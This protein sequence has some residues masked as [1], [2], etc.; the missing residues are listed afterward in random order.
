LI[1]GAPSGEPAEL[2]WIEDTAWLK[3]MGQWN[4]QK[5]VPEVDNLLPMYT[6]LL[7]PDELALY[8]SVA[9]EVTLVSEETINGVRCK[10]YS[11]R[12]EKATPLAIVE[13]EVW[14]AD[15]ADLPP[16]PVRETLKQTV[17]PPSQPSTTPP[18]VEGGSI[19]F[20]E[21]EIYDINAPINIE[22]PE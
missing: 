21:R 10:H 12:Y 7:G 17:Q 2:I 3:M 11:Y 4:E 14:V 6:G 16:I 19:R 15:Q 13:G 1:D 22:P 8:R 18:A 9:T 20:I 5:P